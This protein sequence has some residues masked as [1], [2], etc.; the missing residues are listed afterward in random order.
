METGIYS[1]PV[2]PW[3]LGNHEYGLPWFEQG[4]AYHSQLSPQDQELWVRK[5]EGARS[6]DA[7]SG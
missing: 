4:T 5:R 2:L 1:A 6:L 7:E 3:K